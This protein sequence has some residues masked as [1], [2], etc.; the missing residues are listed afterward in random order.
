LPVG[1]QLSAQKRPV[2]GIEQGMA[3]EPLRLSPG[4]DREQDGHI[5]AALMPGFQQH[6]PMFGEE[7]SQKGGRVGGQGPPGNPA[8]GRAREAMFA[9]GD[10]GF[11]RGPPGKE[12]GQRCRIGI[13]ASRCVG[14]PFPF[15]AQGEG[16]RIDGP[17]Q[18]GIGGL[19]RAAI[20]GG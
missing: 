17:Y 10:P 11:R 1:R 9:F 3:P 5:R 19:R 2:P 8:I 6:A 18:A 4:R 12:G 13:N 14:K 20:A 15:Q 16:A 7:R